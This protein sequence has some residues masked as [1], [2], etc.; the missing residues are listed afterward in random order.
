MKYVA[1][2]I[3]GP[4]AAGKST[5][6]KRVAAHFNYVYID[7]GAMYRAV[8]WFVLHSGK[9]PQNEAECNALLLP[10]IKIKLTPDYRVFLNNIEVTKEIREPHVSGNVSY[11]LLIQKCG[12]YLTAQQR[13]MAKSENVV[14]D[15]RDIGTFVL[16]SADLKIF[17]TASVAVRAERR[18]LENKEKGIKTSLAEIADELK[19]RDHIDSTRSVAPLSKASDAIELDTDNLTIDEVVQ[20]II[21]YV[22]DVLRKK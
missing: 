5:I 1:I 11:M 4:A 8:T 10:N 22:N 18:Y 13:E 21:D 17:Q 12:N 16:P 20:T 14:M 15:G 7:T 6:A 3:D 19:M 2:A 9:D